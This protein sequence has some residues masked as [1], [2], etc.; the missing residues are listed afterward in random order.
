MPDPVG[1]RF[2]FTFRRMLLS[3]DFCWADGAPLTATILEVDD[4]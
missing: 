4:V 1:V 2:W 3:E